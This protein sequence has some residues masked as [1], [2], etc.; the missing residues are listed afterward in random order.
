MNAAE[1]QV[2]ERARE[3][4]LA[5]VEPEPMSGC[6]LWQGHIGGGRQ[7]VYGKFRTGGKGSPTINAHR[8][9][10]AAFSGQPLSTANVV[11]HRCRTPACVNPTHLEAVTQQENLLR[12][13][14]FQAANAR[15]VVC[16]R[17]HE[18]SSENTAVQR[19]R[20]GGKRRI[21]RTCRAERKR[22]AYREKAANR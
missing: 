16:L 15:K 5:F 6:W 4:F 12:G 8:F 20:S 18:F 19:S 2:T 10:F 3:R 17:G 21:C 11:D 14:T 7:R 22:R 1:F 9:A 13:N